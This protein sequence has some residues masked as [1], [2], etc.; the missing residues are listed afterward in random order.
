MNLLT[1]LAE[2]ARFEN[3][4]APETMGPDLISSDQSQSLTDDFEVGET[5]IKANW[6]Q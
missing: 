3:A 1:S 5:P 6:T 4:T 2:R